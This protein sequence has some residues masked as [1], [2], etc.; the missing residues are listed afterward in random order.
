[1]WS[2]YSRAYDGLLDFVPYRTLLRRVSDE[3]RL[4]SARR[5]LDVGCGTGNFLAQCSREH[6]T[7]GL[8]GVD[9]SAAMLRHAPAKLASH[10]GDVELVEADALDHLR[11]IPSASFDRLVAINVLYTLGDREA[12][13]REALRVLEPGG[14]AVV[15]TSTRGG[16]AS[17]MREHLEQKPFH[18]L[19]R[20]KLVA[21]FLIDALISTLARTHRFE[22]PDEAT[23]L[24]EAKRAGAEVLSTSRCYG[25][26]NVLITARRKP[27]PSHPG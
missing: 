22:F 19:L 8:F 27:L 10:S 17:I 26:V 9:A 14:I 23:L 12:F 24:A 15:T 4:H 20:P 6:P 5:L 2:V 11:D 7:L 16:S 21:V 1:M 3:A 25:D 13:W 18:T